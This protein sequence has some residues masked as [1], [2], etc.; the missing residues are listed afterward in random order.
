MDYQSRG[1]EGN[2]ADFT[3][4]YSFSNED[5]KLFEEFL[6]YIKY[7][8]DFLRYIKQ[9]KDRK[10]AI[11]ISI[12]TNKLAPLETV[13]KYLR[14][15]LDCSYNEI[16]LLLNRK[17]G[18]IGVSYRQAKRKFPSRLDVSSTENSIPISVFKN[19]KLTIFETIVVYLKDKDKLK[20]REIAELLNRNYRTIWTVYKRAKKK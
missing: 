15:E 1:K 13:V 4:K 14:E 5:T 8:K 12:F 6:Q 11:P 16:A 9:K 7:K 18:P 17:P 2:N 10:D 19:S 20:F 3:K